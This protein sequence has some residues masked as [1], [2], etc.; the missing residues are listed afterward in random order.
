MENHGLSSPGWLHR[1][2][3]QINIQAD[4]G[5]GNRRTSTAAGHQIRLRHFKRV[6][7]LALDEE[8]SQRQGPEAAAA[9][10]VEDPEQRGAHLGRQVSLVSPLEV[11]WANYQTTVEGGRPPDDPNQACDPL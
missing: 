8:E 3:G 7:S 11:L 6:Q 5:N 10:Q 2:C 9:E 4:E 1:V